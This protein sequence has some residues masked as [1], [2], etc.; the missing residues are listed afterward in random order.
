MLLVVDRIATLFGRLRE[1]SLVLVVADGPLAHATDLGEISQA[2]LTN[3]PFVIAH[4]PIQPH[5]RLNR[6]SSH[7]QYTL[8]VSTVNVRVKT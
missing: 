2:V 4:L 8:T 1:Q 6:D 5:L 7:C 3:G